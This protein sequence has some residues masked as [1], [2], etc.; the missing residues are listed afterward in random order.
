MRRSAQT[1]ITKLG[2]FSSA[3]APGNGNAGSGN[4][5]KES[6]QNRVIFPAFISPLSL[7]QVSSI[8]WICSGSQRALLDSILPLAWAGA[9]EWMSLSLVTRLA[10]YSPI[11]TMHFGRTDCGSRHYETMEGE[12]CIPAKTIERMQE[13]T[14]GMHHQ[15]HDVCDICSFVLCRTPTS[16]YLRYVPSTTS[17]PNQRVLDKPVVADKRKVNFQHKDINKINSK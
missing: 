5:P 2:T 14:C 11:E 8:T 4:A 13:E 1:E 17:T 16:N 3:P 15:Y 7:G 6:V 9:E 12:S 10:R